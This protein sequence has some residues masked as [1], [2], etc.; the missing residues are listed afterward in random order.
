MTF[1]L[2]RKCRLWSRLSSIFLWSMGHIKAIWPIV[3]DNGEVSRKEAGL[4]HPALPELNASGPS[5]QI[6]RVATSQQEGA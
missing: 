6:V 5:S 1:L 3:A 4:I 2:N